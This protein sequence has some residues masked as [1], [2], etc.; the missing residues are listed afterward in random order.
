M[1]KI[2]IYSSDYC[3]YCSAAK[4]LLDKKGAAYDEIVV[5]GRSAVREEMRQKAGGRYT[6]PQIW[7]GDRHV[8]GCDDLYDLDSRGGLDPLLAV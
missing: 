7:I 4:R 3:P 2:T 8:G 6:V 5:D 1:P